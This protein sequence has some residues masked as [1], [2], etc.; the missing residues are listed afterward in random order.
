MQGKT[1]L[2][3]SQ[4][5]WN[6][7]SCLS[8]RPPLVCLLKLLTSGCAQHPFPMAGG[9][10]ERILRQPLSTSSYRVRRSSCHSMGMQT[11]KSFMDGHVDRHSAYGSV[12]SPPNARKEA[13]KPWSVM[14]P[15]FALKL[16]GT[17]CSDRSTEVG[18][19]TRSSPAYTALSPRT[20]VQDMLQAMYFYATLCD[21]A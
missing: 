8:R 9:N 15:C 7:F 5:L 18:I 17:D 21:N 3:T 13:S 19:S 6:F 12:S 20:P 1:L 2:T 16:F 10:R 14:P 4:S 11:S